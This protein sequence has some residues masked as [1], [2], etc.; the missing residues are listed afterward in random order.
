MKGGSLQYLRDQLRT[1]LTPT[2]LIWSDSDPVSPLASGEF[3]AETLPNAELVMIKG[4]GH[5]LMRDQVDE[6]VP[7]IIR[8]LAT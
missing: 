5:F 1:I 4:S 2:L 6:V 7:H 3:L 8:F